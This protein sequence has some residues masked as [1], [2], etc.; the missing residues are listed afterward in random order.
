MRY[1]HSTCL[2]CLASLVMQTNKRIFTRVLS[3]LL[4]KVNSGKSI[5]GQYGQLHH[6]V[7][8]NNK[9]RPE[10]LP[11][12]GELLW[13]HGRKTQ[14]RF[15]PFAWTIL[16]TSVDYSANMASASPVSGLQRD[17]S[18]MIFSLVT[19][20]LISLRYRRSSSI[21]PCSSSQ[22]RLN[23]L[24]LYRARAARFISSMSIWVWIQPWLMASSDFLMTCSIRCVNG[25][26]SPPENR[27]TFI[28]A[29]GVLDS[30][31]FTSGCHCWEV[32]VGKSVE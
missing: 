4:E 5:V 8:A 16:K 26:Q 22:L 1:E 19:S 32:E 6:K 13:D 2:W 14:E 25:Q 29:A 7:G 21:G 17:R 9:Q 3:V 30:P 28:S 11:W 31:C 20:V 23:W 18:K 27:E 24:C 10:N 12:N 15:N